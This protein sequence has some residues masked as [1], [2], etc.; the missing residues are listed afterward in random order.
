MKIRIKTKKE[1]GEA[2]YK[3][4]CKHRQVIRIT[5]NKQEYYCTAKQKETTDYDCRGC[6]LY[7][8]DLPDVVKNIFGGFRR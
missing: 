7:N 8:S 3:M 6:M 4:A 2:G 1:K 5:N